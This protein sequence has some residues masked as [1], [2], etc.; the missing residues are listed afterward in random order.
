MTHQEQID[1]FL[2]SQDQS[3][4]D[5]AA[6]F[7]H[8]AFGQHLASTLMWNFGKLGIALLCCVI[9][10]AWVRKK[11]HSRRQWRT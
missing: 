5:G 8:G 7:F 10:R 2:A 4:A 9:L 1:R 6:S 3:Q 11:L